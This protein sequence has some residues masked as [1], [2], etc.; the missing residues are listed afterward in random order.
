LST[1]CGI[2]RLI[3]GISGVVRGIYTTKAASVQDIRGIFHETSGILRGA[4]GIFLGAG[5]IISEASG[6]IPGYGGI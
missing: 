1:I 3:G 4:G 5:G 2:P 6:I